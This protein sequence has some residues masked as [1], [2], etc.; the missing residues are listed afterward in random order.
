MFFIGKWVFIGREHSE[1]GSSYKKR[2]IITTTRFSILSRLKQV[3]P[4]DHSLSPSSDFESCYLG[5]AI[6]LR[7][8]LNFLANQPSPALRLVE[9]RNKWNLRV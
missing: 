4:R 2:G 5:N 9:I 7:G 6:F 1:L 8:R 3:L